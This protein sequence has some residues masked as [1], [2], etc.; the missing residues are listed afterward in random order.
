MIPFQGNNTVRFG[1]HNYELSAATSI[2]SPAT[3]IND[4]PYTF[5]VSLDHRLRAWNLET[6]NVAYVGDIL[7]EERQ[8]S[9]LGKF[10]IHPSHSQLLKV[11]SQGHSHLAVTYS[12]IGA[13]QFKFWHVRLSPDIVGGLDLEDMFA[14]H[15]LVPPTPTEEVW[16]M[17]DFSVVLH[18]IEKRQAL[19]VLWKN[20]TTYRVQ[21]LEF[22]FMSATDMS[23]AWSS[24]WSSMAAETID[25]TPLPTVLPSD[26]LDSTDKWLAYILYP[27]RYTESTIET[28]LS[29]YEHGMG[30]SKDGSS[31]RS[32][33]LAERM[34]TL[35][36]ST[37]SLNSTSAG[38]VDFDQYRA[39][40]D[41]QWRRFYRLLVELN[42]Q[43]GEALSFVH[44]SNS[45]LPWLITADGISAVRECCAA[46]LLLHNP[47]PVGETSKAASL[48]A[49]AAAFRDTFS[50]GVLQAYDS[51]LSAELFQDSS[52]GDSE[53]IK[54]LYEKSNIE[55]Q[56]S[57]DDLSQ[58]ER[59]L[60]DGLPGLTDRVYEILLASMAVTEDVTQKIERLPLTGF[61]KRTAVRGVQEI[62]NIYHKI[63][64]DQLLLIIFIDIEID[65][66]Q[67]GM[68][69][70]TT[71]IFRRLLAVLKQLE[72][73]KWL[74]ETR[75]SVPLKKTDGA[76]GMEMGSNTSK[77][78]DKSMQTYT[79]LEGCIGHLLGLE[80]PQSDGKDVSSLITHLLTSVCDS[81]CD[82]EIQP[83]VIQCF[84]LRNER[85]DLAMEFS[86]FC[87]QDPFST[88]I[89]GRTYL[90]A[91]DFQ[92]AALNFK[93]AAFG[94]CKYRPSCT[95]AKN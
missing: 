91:G 27:G 42:K 87:G 44:S 80:T 48:V 1:N 18:E 33:N 92:I 36:A 6:G 89:Q 24:A 9:Q 58:L 2:T 46:E 19:W 11:Y 72:Q 75:I 79:V 81:D 29:I 84:L 47:Q 68:N 73:F 67:E 30:S 52:L 93:K 32:H 50:D 28:A 55:G 14:G 60:E 63:C 31:R 39:A 69:L 53:R 20:N 45:A 76:A 25:E 22:G 83:A 13:G 95:R 34:C 7:G 70:E 94:I 82:L 4:V 8:P 56:V 49:A 86:R 90:A 51:A 23:K 77:T 62:V 66:T 40:T 78:A 57:D 15:D 21:R 88:Y 17:A 85:V 5:T 59:T 12:P 3:L 65:Q 61:G 35:I 37:T 16:T 10:V 26:P 43:R 71:L 74:A 41:T 54:L 38:E 64:A